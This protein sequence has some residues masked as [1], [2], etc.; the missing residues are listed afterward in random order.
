M[1]RLDVLGDVG[2][3]ACAVVRGGELPYLL[4]GASGKQLERPTGLEVLVAA[5]T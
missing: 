2:T 4:D 3:F 1:Q 5:A